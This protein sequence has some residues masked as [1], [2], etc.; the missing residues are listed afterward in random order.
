[1]RGTTW[2]CVGLMLGAMVSLANPA[3]A[4]PDSCTIDTSAHETT[5]T[6]R[7]HQNNPPNDRWYF[8]VSVSGSGVVS[9]D[10][11][12]GITVASCSDIDGSCWHGALSAVNADGTCRIFSGT[13]ATCGSNPG[14]LPADP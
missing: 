5:C 6:F 13:T 14:P 4:T 11:T 12:C 8:F 9:G 2:L 1:M 3:Q 10:A 7:C